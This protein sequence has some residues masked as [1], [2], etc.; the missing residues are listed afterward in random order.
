MHLETK[1]IP[2]H[3]KNNWIMWCSYGLF[4]VGVLSSLFVCLPITYEQFIELSSNPFSDWS[5]QT[6]F[7]R[8]VLYGVFSG[9]LM[10]VGCL[11]LLYC[12]MEGSFSKFTTTIKSFFR[13]LRRRIVLFWKRQTLWMKLGFALLVL[14]TIIIRLIHMNHS[15]E[16]D[17]AY[18]YNMFVSKGLRQVCTDYSV[19]NNHVFSSV[20]IN[21]CTRVFGIG[22]WSL[23]LPA[24]LSGILIPILSF[25]LFK[26][27]FNFRTA[28]LTGLF[29]AVSV[30]QVYFSTC[31]RGYTLLGLLFL[32][33]LC[34]AYLIITQ[35]RFIPLYWAGFAVSISLSIYTMPSGVFPVG[36][37]CAWLILMLLVGKNIKERKKKLISFMVAIPTA[38]VLTLLLYLPLT[39]RYG[40]D[41]LTSNQFIAQQKVDSIWPVLP[42]LSQKVFHHWTIEFPEMIQSLILGLLII[43]F[44]LHFKTIK[45]RVS[46]FLAVVFW[47]L[48]VMLVQKTVPFNRTLG[49]I[50]PF[51][52]LL[53]AVAIDGGCRLVEWLKPALGKKLTPLY[54]LCFL[55]LALAL[56]W[57][58]VS[59]RIIYS[60][61]YLG[62]F[63]SV[64]EYREVILQDHDPEPLVIVPGPAHQIME[65]YNKL[66]MA[67]IPFV[68][69]EAK[70][71]SYIQS[72]AVS[73]KKIWFFRRVN[74]GW[75]S[76]EKAC[77]VLALNQ[78][79][80]KIVQDDGDCQLWV[81][82][83]P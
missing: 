78:N 16:Y 77:E 27:C 49:Y 37:A 29:L 47:L 11:G 41:C 13:F 82:I 10:V 60:L 24:L 75:P 80:F 54:G 57:N 62:K 70:A 79:E 55:V 17:E 22:V 19:P 40:Y 73:G 4:V 21:L 8:R 31:A 23:R 38:G 43:G 28:L 83:I 34:F 71:R 9:A 1:K 64:H 6:F 33:S 67:P 58:L 66:E 52:Y 56:C 74:R 7:K 69:P 26:G 3:H 5:P 44:V 53:P 39:A 15:F 45:H 42:G 20:L 63:P 35:I 72:K 30:D 18:T 36:G 61:D 48:L 46:I 81:L 2:L 59:T 14:V 76:M 32:L 50:L 51:Y 68:F 65:Y 12:S 25:F